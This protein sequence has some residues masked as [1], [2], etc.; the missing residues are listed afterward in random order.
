ME[1]DEIIA[2]SKEP[3]ITVETIENLLE[4]LDALKTKENEQERRLGEIE[5]IS[6]I[7]FG[8]TSQGYF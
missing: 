4:K 5:R 7:I 8:K 1:I 3:E 2:K 6:K